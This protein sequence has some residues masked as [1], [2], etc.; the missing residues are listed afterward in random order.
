MIKKTKAKEEKAKLDF[1]KQAQEEAE[2]AEKGEDI[3]SITD[4]SL[5]YEM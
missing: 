2:Q 1:I 3:K 4:S 5:L